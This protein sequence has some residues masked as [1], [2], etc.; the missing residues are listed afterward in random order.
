MESTGS[1]SAVVLIGVPL[2]VVGSRLASL[3]LPQGLLSAQSGKRWSTLW[4]W[5]SG[6][7]L[8]M[9]GVGGGG[10]ALVVLLTMSM[11]FLLGRCTRAPMAVSP[12]YL[13]MIAALIPAAGARVVGET[14]SLST[15]DVQVAFAVADSVF[16]LPGAVIVALVRQAL[17]SLS[18]GVS[19]GW[20]LRDTPPS[21]IGRFAA[22]LATTFIAQALPSAAVLFIGGTVGPALV[23]LALGAI[24]H[25]LNEVTFCFLA[26]AG[27]VFARSFLLV[28]RQRITADPPATHTRGKRQGLY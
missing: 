8:L 15:I 12:V 16:G 21:D 14:V 2:L 5:W 17:L 19:V 7:V 22:G 23:A 13:G 1:W 26:L 10:L 25:I 20:G 27:A 6:A 28:H 24:L 3:H 9:Y 11:G 4:P 18:F